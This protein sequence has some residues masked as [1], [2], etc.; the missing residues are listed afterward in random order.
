[1]NKK[2][3]LIGLAAC[4]TCCAG[5]A[6]AQEANNSQERQQHEKRLPREVPNP[7]KIA[8]LMTNQMKESLQLTD[9]QYKK[10]YKLNLKEQK[11]FFK[12]MQNSG[13][14]RPP[15]GGPGMRG[16]RPPMGGGG[17]PPMM[18][19]GGF[20]ERVGGGAMMNRESSS[21]DSQKKAAEA[22]E[23]KIKKILSPEQYEKWQTEQA[24]ARKKASQRRTPKD[25]HSSVS[26]VFDKKVQ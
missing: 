15:M 12:S 24:A 8:T 13:E 25:G 22:K 6:N 21:A 18:G 26:P 10:I 1:M 7:E 5:L 23:K 14:Q 20:P 3:K 4:L 2:I 17:E 9:K 19:E 16:G 11:E